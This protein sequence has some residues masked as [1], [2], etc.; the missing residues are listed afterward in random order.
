M[1]NGPQDSQL[2]ESPCATASVYCKFTCQ[3]RLADYEE[4]EPKLT[5]RRLFLEGIPLISPV[6]MGFRGNGTVYD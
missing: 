5:S 4:Y 1:H 6:C 2:R 3:K